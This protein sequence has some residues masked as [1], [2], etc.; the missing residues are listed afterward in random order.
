MATPVLR[1]LRPSTVSMAL[2]T[3]L[4]VTSLFFLAQARQDANEIKPGYLLLFAVILFELFI[5][6]ILVGKGLFRLI[7]QYRNQSV[8]S[9]LTLRLFLI[10]ISLSLIPVAIVYL[11]SLQFIFKGIDSRLGSEVGDTLQS[12]F[13]L[14]QSVLDNRSHEAIQKAKGFAASLHSVSDSELP[15]RLRQIRDRELLDEILLVT[16]DGRILAISSDRDSLVPSTRITDLPLSSPEPRFDIF[17]DSESKNL[18]IRTLVPFQRQ[19]GLHQSRVILISVFPVNP[20]FSQ[21]IKEIQATFSNYKRILFLRPVMKTSFTVTLSLV[22]LLCVLAAI[23]TAFY[24]ARR[25]VSPLRVL[26]IGTRAVAAGHY[27]KQLP[28]TSHD[29]VGLLVSSF[30]KMSK[31]IAQARDEAQQHQ[32]EVE[33]QRGYLEAVLLNISSG[34]IV[35]DEHMVLNT[36]NSAAE[37]ILDCNLKQFHHTAIHRI[38]TG[39]EDIRQLFTLFYQ[40][41]KSGDAASWHMEL[42]YRRKNIACRGTSL[43]LHGGQQGH[44]ISINDI[45]AVIQAQK[46]AAW[47]EVAERLA[48]EI[49]NPLTPIQLSAERLNRKYSNTSPEKFLP[50]LKRSTHTIIQQVD[51]LKEMINAFNE[52]AR[53]P[54]VSLQKVAPSRLIHEVMDLYVGHREDIRYELHIDENLPDMQLDSG[55]I[56]QLLHNLIKNSTEAIKDSPEKRISL[57]ACRETVEGQEQ[58]TLRITDTGPGF[59]KDMLDSIFDPYITDK[60]KGS[61]LGLAI[62]KKI[63][64]EHNG[65]II[66]SNLPTGGACIS[67]HFPV[68]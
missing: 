41:I 4:I 27:E 36:Y 43:M 40:R 32:I 37:K 45:T 7:R 30:N 63:V 58:I 54:K 67:I 3:L 16:T 49:K 51:A 5:L 50:I 12:A 18:E 65:R 64:E 47:S 38:E 52:Y 8:G 24:A 44:V 48:H 25:I 42:Q 60:P 11:F 57:T 6:I 66:A 22:L 15:S 28:Q 31:K 62:A 55:R 26:A 17:E 1:L 23:W 39:D 9:R 46:N 20:R 14:S 19:T 53:P 35:L 56:R 68:G 21:L 59:R 2:L 34:V 13:N 33:Q 10:F 29:E 61:G